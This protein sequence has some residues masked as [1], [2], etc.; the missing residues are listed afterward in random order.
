MK[1]TLVVGPIWTNVVEFDSPFIELVKSI[2][3][4]NIPNAQFSAAFKQGTWDG[5]KRLFDN[6]RKRFLTGF[7]DMIK[8][9]VAEQGGE[10]QILDENISKYCF[11]VH[12]EDIKLMDI[13]W[14]R[15]K[16]VQLPILQEIGRK[17]RGAIKLATGGGKTE[18]I[19]GLCSVLKDKKVLVLVHRLELLEQTKAKL[20]YRLQEKIGTIESGKLDIDKRVVVGM[21]MSVYS[22]VNQLYQW[23]K[24]VDVL[25]I[26]ECHHSGADT[27]KKIAMMCEATTRVGFSGTPL[28]NKIDKDMSLI[29]LTGNIIQ[30]FQVSDLVEL[31]YATKPVIRIINDGRLVFGNPKKKWGKK[32]WEVVSSVYTDIKF[33][34]VVGEL[35]QAH[36]EKGLVIFVDRVEVGNQIYDSLRK[37]WQ[38]KKIEFSHGSLPK[39]QR[40][41]IFER[42]KK[43]EL[44]VLVCT[45]I[46]DE[47]VDVQGITGVLFACST[48][49]IVKIMQRIGR[50]VRTGTNKDQLYV[51]DLNIIAPWLFD[52]L[53]ERIKLYSEEKFEINFVKL[54]Q[55]NG[56]VYG[57]TKAI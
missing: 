32:Y 5:K 2:L 15:F 30:G 47:G 29:G 27:W 16:K 43:G 1:A 26:D 48:K 4:V 37:V 52:H 21:V 54:Y 41:Q 51:Y 49:S 19:A 10:L 11:E 50:G 42:L 57:F 25:L 20:E 31:G 14:E 18:I 46:L 35:T 13:D 8:E 40:L 6:L 44:D 34:D 17:G 28:T 45:P 7:L 38:Y 23:L 55:S 39:F 56:G 36:N 3:T 53:R 12:E 33:L 24:N 9:K 22:R